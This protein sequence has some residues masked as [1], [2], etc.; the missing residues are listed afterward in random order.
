MPPPGNL[1]DKPPQS[2]I[3]VSAGK[4]WKMRTGVGGEVRRD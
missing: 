3:A 2:L 1:Q 4:S